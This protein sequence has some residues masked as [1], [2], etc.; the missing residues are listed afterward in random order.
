M[1]YI[2]RR[3]GTPVTLVGHVGDDDLQEQALKPLRDM[4]V[5]LTNVRTVHNAQTAVSMI[6]VLPDGKKHIILAPNA[7]DEWED[8]EKEQVQ[9]TIKHAP[10]ES[11]LVAD[12]EVAPFIVEAAIKAAQEKGFPV[13]LDPSPADRINKHLLAG[14]CYLVPD[15][16]ETESLT[17]IM[18]DT[19]DKAKDAARKLLQEG[20]QNVIV[21]MKD[22]GCVAANKKIVVHVPTIPV[23]VVDSTG[24]GDAF[25]GALAVAILEK[26]PL[27]EAACFAS[28]ASLATVT[29]YG[30]QPAYPTRDRLE[31]FYDETFDKIQEL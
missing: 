28:A 30:S 4:G 16:S 22:G 9:R 3:L 2:A 5:D 25:A 17:G 1:A 13:I 7:N 6:A 29:A 21:K 8:Q 27:E 20:V 31:H 24:A 14:I 18:P 11:V 19:I 10:D 15:A 12:Y 26:K 23:E